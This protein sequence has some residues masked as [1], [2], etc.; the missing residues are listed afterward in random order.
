[1][2][3]QKKMWIFLGIFAIV[4]F[5]FVQIYTAP[6][7]AQTDAIRQRTLQSLLGS[8]VQIGTPEARQAALDELSK[9][10]RQYDFYAK[11]IR[12]GGAEAMEYLDNVI[13][14]NNAAKCY[15]N[16][17]ELK[18]LYIPSGQLPA[19]LPPQLNDNIK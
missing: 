5:I 14:C 13:L 6:L 7:R 12:A 16:L 9:Y 10:K 2:S 1:M 11:E 15:N 18:D 8:S 3:S 19:G 4:G 17:A